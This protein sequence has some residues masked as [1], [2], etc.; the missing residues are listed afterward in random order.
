M[1]GKNKIDS[2]GRWRR[3]VYGWRRRGVITGRRIVVI[4]SVPKV[5][6][7]SF[8]PYWPVAISIVI[9]VREYGGENYSDGDDGQYENFHGPRSHSHA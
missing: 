7:V 1:Y 6:S 8:V 4:L 2:R 3:R 5:A 9:S